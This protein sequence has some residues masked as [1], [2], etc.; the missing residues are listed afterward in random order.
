MALALPGYHIIDQ[1]S[2]NSNSRVYRGYRENDR[3]P[4]VFKVLDRDYPTSTELARYQREYDL[5]R[6]LDLDGVIKTYGLEKHGNGLVLL[7]ED[8]GGQSLREVIQKHRFTLAELLRMA[9]RLSEILGQVHAAH[10]IHKDVNPGNIVI[11]PQNDSMPVIKLIDFGLATQVSREMP[12]VK[13]IHVLEGMLAYISPEQTGRMNR[14]LD[15]RTDQYS[16][17]VTLYELLTGNLP[18]AGDDPLEIIHGHLA[19]QPPDPTGYQELTGLTVPPALARIA[20]K[21]LSKNAEDRYQSANGLIADL[22]Q[23]LAQV[24][25]HPEPEH[26]AVLDFPIG[27]KDFSERF[28]IPEKLY[29]RQEEIERLTTIFDRAAEGSKQVVFCTGQPGIGKSALINELHKPITARRGYFIGGKYDL[30][31][32]NLPYTAIS[33]AFQDL[34][35]QLLSESES[36][37]AERRT[38]IQRSV[39]HN[40]QVV[41]EVIPNLELI[42]GPQPEIEPLAPDKA[43]N[44][45]NLVFQEFIRA[46]AGPDHPLVLFLDDLQWADGA[47]LRFIETFLDN[48]GLGYFLFIGA[49]RDNEVGSDH[50]LTVL[51]STLQKRGILGEL[52]NVGPLN[53]AHI[54]QMAA[55]TLHCPVD[56]TVALAILIHAKTAGNPFFTHEFLQRLYR[57]RLIELRDGYWRHDLAG[58]AQSGITDNVVELMAHKI[59]QLPSPA[60]HVLQAAACIGFESSLDVL[61]AV[62]GKPKTEILGD[63]QS[64]FDEGLLIQIE[65]TARFV[66]DRIRD[67]AYTLIVAEERRSLHYRIGQILLTN[68]EQD[69]QEEMIFP[70]ANQ[71]NQAHALLTIDEA[72]KV[73]RINLKAGR[74]A[75]DSTAYEAALELF[76]NGAALLPASPWETAYETTLDLYTHWAEAAYLAAHFDNAERLFAQVLEH[77]RDVFDRVKIYGIQ[78]EYH[79][80]RNEFQQAIETGHL[81]LKQLGLDLPRKASS[82][83]ILLEFAKADVVLGRRQISDLIDLPHM[84][85]KRIRAAC[86]ILW[87]TGV[88]AY[89]FDKKLFSVI[90]TKM[91]ILS[92]R[93]GNA[94]VSPTGYAGY[95][96]GLVVLGRIEKSYESLKLGVALA[97]KYATKH[98]LGFAYF[99]LAS[100][101]HPKEPFAKCSAYFQKAIEYS[102]ESG[103]LLSAASACGYTLTFMFL[104]GE[105]LGAIQAASGH[106]ISIIAASKQDLPRL[107]SN[108]ILQTLANLRGESANPAKLTGEF[109]DEEKALPAMANNNLAMGA[110]YANKIRL[111]YWF[112]DLT[113]ETDSL[114]AADRGDVGGLGTPTEPNYFFYYGLAWA[115]LARETEGNARVQCRQ[116]VQRA[117]QKLKKLSKTC[118]ANYLNKYQLLSAELEALDGKSD[119]A[120]RLYDQAI[121]TAT[122]QGFRHEEAIA[123][124]CAAHFYEARGQDKVAAAYLRDAHYGYQQ[125]ECRPKVELLEEKYPF[126]RAQ[127]AASNLMTITTSSSQ[128]ASGLDLNAI[129]KASQAISGEIVLENLLRRMM[130]LILE[131]AGAQRGLLLLEQNERWFI[132]ARLETDP[133]E[134]ELLTSVPSD[135]ARSPA[136]LA[137]P[138]VQYVIRTGESVV[139][140]DATQK[141][142]L[143]GSEYLQTRHPQSLLCLPLRNQARLSG[144]LYLE[145]NLSTGAFTADRLEVLNLLSSQMAVSLD[146]AILYTR[147]EEL[148]TA[149]T[150]RLQMVAHLS[151]Q[152]NAILDLERLL[153]ELVTQVKEQFNYYHVQI[154]MV[155]HPAQKMD[156]NVEDECGF[157]RLAAGYGEAGARMKAE[158]LY[159][160]LDAEIGLMVQAVCQR[161][162]MRADDVYQNKNWL[163]HP[164]LPDTRS[165]MAA[166]IIAEDR[167]IGVLD[168]QSDR[169]A[170]LD[171]GDADL[172]QSLANQVAIAITN[173]RLFAEAEAAKER[174]E[175]AS[176]A[177]SEFLSSMSHELRTPLNG[178]LGYAQ[179]L[180]R[181]K[182]L[183]SLQQN[184]LNIIQQSGEHLL[185]LINDILDLSKVEAGRLD[186][187]PIHFNLSDCLNGVAGIIRIR[188]QQKGISFDLEEIPP[189]PVAVYADEKRL[190]Q[191]LINLLNN[192]VKFTDRGHVVLRVA[193]AEGAGEAGAAVKLHFEVQDTGVGIAAA[194]LARIFQP[195]EQAGD[196]QRKAEGTG[197]GLSITQRLLEKMGSEL[198][199]NS[200]LGEGSTFW[201]EAVFPLGE[202]QA[203]L[204]DLAKRAW[205]VTGYKGRPRKVLVVDD[206]QHGR[207]LLVNTL[208][209]LGFVVAEAANGREGIQLAQEQ[210]PDLILMDMMMPVMTGFEAAQVIRQIPELQDVIIFGVSASVIEEDQQQ[211]VIAGCNAFISKPVVV[212]KLLAL[213]EEHLKLEWVHEE[214][215]EPGDGTSEKPG[216]SDEQAVPP[217]TEL[218]K[219][220]ALARDGKMRPIREQAAQWKGQ[221][222]AYAVFADKVI[223]LAQ[224]FQD[225]KILALIEPYLEAKA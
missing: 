67:A 40:G 169:P 218:Q 174:A 105:K 42:I 168:V 91:V 7:L 129:I 97:E 132:Q 95:A 13:N 102:L 147:M 43:Q 153:T 1:I 213:I 89:V 56:N 179:I 162:V 191:V 113:G 65:D 94:P 126:L 69:P 180:R 63:L 51:M 31:K 23:C 21:L 28:Q 206:K 163:A 145:N 86:D 123:N 38:A 16:F 15:Y 208:E 215:V 9:L 35:R 78:I 62:V 48:P 76:R 142:R 99:L 44:R 125:W 185:T 196:G 24:E 98:I 120:Q 178:I 134:V 137:I 109:F 219:I 127:P 186:L 25:A 84:A 167:V 150:Q 49:Y 121:K 112:E 164:L 202:T 152:L 36:V 149:R 157:L 181:G 34:V 87:R 88:T 101:A 53:E 144:I 45:F 156:V 207:D 143:V 22:E 212:S 173:A 18:F 2:E 135:Q 117:Q 155:E 216:A 66:H 96:I 14:S 166:P 5:L 104:Q 73:T 55:D 225:E 160:P 58:I 154:Y 79:T 61:A 71:L 124:E 81:A 59:D 141:E 203:Q 214:S 197:L 171:D 136:L 139:L 192:A 161:E 188:A 41:L 205:Q 122:E 26:L 209:P 77:A 111:D 221:N 177:K 33:Q 52:F 106:Y 4:L 10:I 68:Y 92:I 183:T 57:D 118:P 90:V 176:R 199:V 30:F 103:E 158:N 85:D 223:E 131:N 8:F 83:T 190:R 159:I 100:F 82:L 130:T 200:R 211:I 39:G 50:P 165:E 70:L 54:A 32:R 119:Q 75:K 27:A 80:G 201:F 222:P 108:I 184:G 17:G 189:L 110:Y 128:S 19:K 172:M 46:L 64:A 193:L 170:G 29:G 107:T 74:K 6:S 47:S 148:V 175:V 133:E 217:A 198:R 60:W 115:R 72:K 138:V 140:D 224:N 204:A 11:G 116:R 20:L 114:M 146:N 12:L 37:L 220:H 195:F 93:Y 210:H 182:D 194:D 151:G 3:L 187:Y